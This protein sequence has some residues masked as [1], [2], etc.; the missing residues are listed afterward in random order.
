MAGVFSDNSYYV[1]CVTN[2]RPEKESYES[3]NLPLFEPGL[4]SLI[5]TGINSGKITFPLKSDI[6]FEDDAII[7]LAHDT[8]VNDVD[9]SDL[10]DFDID[11]QFVL[12]GLNWNNQILIS[13]QVPVGTIQKK[14]KEFS[15]THPRLSDQIS[16]LPENLRL[17]KAIERFRN[18]PLPVIGTS[19]LNHVLWR[20]FFKFVNVEIHFCTQAEAELLKHA[21]NS[22][23]AMTISFGNEIFRLG[24]EFGSDGRMVIELLEMEPRIGRL[25]PKKPGLPFFGGTLARDLVSLKNMT[26]A[27]KVSAPILENVLTS[28]NHHKEYVL[29]R[30]LE[31]LERQRSKDLSIC[32]LGLTYTAETSTLRRS[33]GLW[34]AQ[35]LLSQN[36]NVV[37]YDPRVI[38]QSSDFRI[39]AEV[40]ELEKHKV[41]CFILVSPWPSL[42][43]D[44]CHFVTS[45]HFIDIDG[46][47][48]QHG[49]ELP[50]NYSQIF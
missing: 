40:R 7:I 49:V 34:L 1:S 10:G 12:D 4:A 29:K 36:F 21:L 45:E 31:L 20:D 33:P 14:I 19:P 9:E 41:D 22:Y 15:E 48:S 43:S 2:S 18:P 38:D 42:K 8:K 30:I 17:G 39:F 37:A 44:V 5:E 16:Y 25:S 13:A 24:E 27:S 28:N 32:I 3:L 47:L 6:D 26:K 23:L 35:E 11:F 50:K 46:H